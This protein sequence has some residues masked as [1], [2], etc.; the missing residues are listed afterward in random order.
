MSFDDGLMLGLMLGGGGSSPPQSEDWEPPSS[1]LTVPE[2]AA[3]EVKVLIDIRTNPTSYLCN[4]WGYMH[5]GDGNYNNGAY[6]IDYGNGVSATVPQGCSAPVESIYPYTATGQYIITFS[7]TARFY[8]RAVDT[9]SSP[10]ILMIKYGSGIGNGNTGY[11]TGNFYNCSRL[12]YIKFGVSYIGQ[13]FIGYNKPQNLRRADFV[14]NPL[15][16]ADNAFSNLYVL[17][18]IKG[19]ESITTIGQYAFWGCYSLHKIDASSCAT[20]GNYAFSNC[21]SLSSATF[22]DGCTFGN[23]AFNGCSNLYPIPN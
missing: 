21:I 22:A 14:D 1:W 4:S 19:V 11:Q 23:N 6:D 3:N 5:D 17:A 10:T 16:I 7:S 13:N 18:T 2:P 8:Y 15:T 9:E 20:V 12:Q